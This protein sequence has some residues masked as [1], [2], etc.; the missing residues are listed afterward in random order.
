MDK[1]HKTILVVEG[2]HEGLVKKTA[3][4][5]PDGAAEQYGAVLKKLDRGVKIAITRPHFAIDPAAPVVWQE[6]DGVAFTGAGVYWAADTAEAAPARQIMETAFKRGLPVFGSC[7]GMQLGVAVLGGRLYANPSGPEIAIARDIR[8]SDAG[9]THAIYDGKPEIFDALCMHR[10]D[11]LDSGNSLSILSANA[12][13]GVQAVASKVADILFWGVQYHPELY[14][15][16]IADYLERSDVEGFSQIKQ[17]AGLS[18]AAG[19][20][21]ADIAADFRLLDKEGDVQGLKERYA[22]SQALTDRNIHERELSNW[23]ASITGKNL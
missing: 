18:L 22:I 10:D 1:A 3:S 20:S 6:I 8:L 16:Q 23:L 19:Q 9:K 11:V 7:Y 13:C 2:N 21:A 15:S 12:H 14:F 5:K 17:L 4:G